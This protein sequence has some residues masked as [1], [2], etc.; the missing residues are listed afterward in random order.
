MHF[1]FAVILI[2]FHLITRKNYG[3]QSSRMSMKETSFWTGYAILFVLFSLDIPPVESV[4]FFFLSSFVL[5]IFDLFDANKNG[6]IGFEEFVKTLSVFHPNTPKAV[7]IAR[8]KM[9]MI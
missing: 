7:K 5:Q 9:D 8:K 1:I 6:R 3:L 4:S 2:S